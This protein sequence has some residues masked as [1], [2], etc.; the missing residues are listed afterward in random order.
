MEVLHPGKCEKEVRIVESEKNC[1]EDRVLGA[2]CR[3]S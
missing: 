1:G 3:K 2:V